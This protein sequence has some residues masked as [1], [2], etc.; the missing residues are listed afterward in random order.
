MKV[1]D[2]ITEL[3]KCDQGAE[4]KMHHHMGNTALFVC[5]ATN[6]PGEVWIEDKGDI[7]LRVEIDARIENC[8][9]VNET[10]FKELKKI[11]V[12]LRDIQ[13]YYPEIYENAKKYYK[14]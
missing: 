8:G 12:T 11:G 4:V 3:Q 1:K 14:N 7:D 2:L 9:P 10:F 6:I 5:E 13:T